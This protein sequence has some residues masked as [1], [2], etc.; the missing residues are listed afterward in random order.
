MCVRCILFVVD[1]ASAMDMNNSPWY[2]M[3]KI[4]EIFSDPIKTI[5]VYKNGKKSREGIQK[6]FAFIIYIRATHTGCCDATI[7]VD[8]SVYLYNGRAVEDI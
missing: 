2:F 7:K 8:E 3:R 6:G 4:R 5:L 1:D